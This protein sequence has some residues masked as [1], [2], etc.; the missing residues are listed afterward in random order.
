MRAIES[1]LLP[2]T[3]TARL[4]ARASGHEHRAEI[5]TT[6]PGVEAGEELCGA[7]EEHC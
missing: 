1:R 5:E 3:P 7:P 4:Q 2:T 6:M